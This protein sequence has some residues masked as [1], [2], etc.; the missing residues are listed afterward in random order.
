MCLLFL[1][2]IVSCT[3][4]NEFTPVYASATQT[5]TVNEPMTANQYI[6]TVSASDMDSSDTTDGIILYEILSG[7]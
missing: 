6:A 3:S 2:Y 1:R 7:K 5:I 4:V